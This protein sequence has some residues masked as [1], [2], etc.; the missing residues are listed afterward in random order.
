MVDIMG[1]Q[2]GDTFVIDHGEY[3]YTKDMVV[4]EGLA[5]HVYIKHVREGLLTLRN[6]YIIGFIYFGNSS[7]QKRPKWNQMCW[8]LVGQSAWTKHKIWAKG[9][10]LKIQGFI[11]TQ[12]QMLT[13]DS[14]QLVVLGKSVITIESEGKPHYELVLTFS[15]SCILWCVI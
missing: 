3:F 12:R 9:N 1:A 15:C 13:C 11:G 6:I 10:D 14:Q 2:K 7:T 5:E 8:I 4:N